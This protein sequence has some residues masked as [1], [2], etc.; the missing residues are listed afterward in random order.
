M[1]NESIRQNDIAQAPPAQENNET[2]PASAGGCLPRPCSA[3][4]E[5][6]WYLQPKFVRFG[7]KVWSLITLGTRRGVK[8]PK[9]LHNFYPTLPQGSKS[10]AQASRGQTGTLFA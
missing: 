4:S 5:A 10:R 8:W 3:W 6:R 7:R 2:P 1:N 9:C